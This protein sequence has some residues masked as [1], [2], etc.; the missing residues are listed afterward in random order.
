[1]HGTEQPLVIF[2]I[3]QIRRQILR[4]DEIQFLQWSGLQ[5]VKEFSH[6]HGHGLDK[7]VYEIPRTLSQQIIHRFIVQIEGGTVD[8]CLFADFFHR[9]IG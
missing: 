7:P 4:C 3:V 9:D 1:M 8:P 6:I 2:D 5:L